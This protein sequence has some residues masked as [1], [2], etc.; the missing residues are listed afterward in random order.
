MK[1]QA[2]VAIGLGTDVCRIANI[3]RFSK[4]PSGFH[5]QDISPGCKS[6]IV[7]GIALPREKQPTL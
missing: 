5:P 7:F 3:D 1:R 6:V 4:A 2:A